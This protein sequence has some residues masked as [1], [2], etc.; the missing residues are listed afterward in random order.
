MPK[1]IGSLG[2][3]GVIAWLARFCR[4]ILSKFV[5]K[6]PNM[7]SDKYS[8][9]QVPKSQKISNEDYIDPTPGLTD[10]LNM[11]RRVLAHLEKQAAGY[12]ALTIPAPLQ[13]ELEDKRSEVDRLEAE[14]ARRQARNR[15]IKYKVFVAP[16]DD[17]EEECAAVRWTIEYA[18]DN[19]FK[20][21]NCELEISNDNDGI[22]I[23][24]GIL[25]KHINAPIVAPTSKCERIDQRIA[26]A[27]DAR[28][29]RGDD[30][31][32]IMLYMKTDPKPT[33]YAHQD[34]SEQIDWFFRELETAKERFLVPAR[35]Q[36]RKTMS[37]KEKRLEFLLLAHLYNLVNDL[38]QEDRS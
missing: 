14:V 29:E 24:I 10:T 38:L 1:K 23:F 31:P 19:L 27:F 13:I 30:R 20:Q 2:F 9:R 32:A 18:S 6:H 26:C 15:F 5:L 36:I 21:V 28:R 35:L 4:R 16:F 3:R 8:P 22:D 12:T 37:D 17:T 33:D 7:A 34:D 11:A 25:W